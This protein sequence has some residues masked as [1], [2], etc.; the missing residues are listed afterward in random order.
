MIDH[1]VPCPYNFILHGAAI[2]RCL[3]PGRAHLAPIIKYTVLR[4]MFS[5][6]LSMTKAPS[7][8]NYHLLLLSGRT[9]V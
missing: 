4:I 9:L 1:M 2:E 7:C 6:Q 5:V 8:V 3:Q